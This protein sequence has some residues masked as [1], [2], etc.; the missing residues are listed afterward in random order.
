MNDKITKALERYKE[1]TGSALSGSIRAVLFDMDGVLY[2]SMPGH[3]RAWKQMCDEEG[4]ANNPDEFFGYEG[5]TGAATIN[6]LYNRQF[7]HGATEADVKR[8]YARKSELFKAQGAPIIMPGAQDAVAEVLRAGAATVLVTGSGQASLLER[9]KAHYPGAFELRVTA[10]DVKHGK[11]HPEPFLTGLAKAGVAADMA[12]AVDNAPLGVESA[13]RAGI[14]TIGVRT[15]P[16]PA[17]ALLQA[18]A[19]IE[20]DSMHECTKVLSFLFK[21]I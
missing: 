4:I 20:L 15:G 1:R 17:G 12:V 5:M 9:L 2:D 3:A 10:Y 7:G 14:F 8:M 18:G 6:L 21:H 19:D 11:P 13:S 16:I